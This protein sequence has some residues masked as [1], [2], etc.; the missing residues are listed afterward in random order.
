MQEFNQPTPGRTLTLHRKMAVAFRDQALFKVFETALVAV[1]QLQSSPQG[2]LKQEVCFCS[3][4][5]A[6]YC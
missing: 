1:R 3:D 5:T 2:K 4:N 6:V